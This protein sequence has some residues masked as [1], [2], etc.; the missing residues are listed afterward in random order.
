MGP[1]RKV[2]QVSAQFARPRKPGRRCMPGRKTND[3]PDRAFT[4]LSAHHKFALLISGVVEQGSKPP[5]N[6]QW[7]QH[8]SPPHSSRYQQRIC[9]GCPPLGLCCAKCLQR[10]NPCILNE[11]VPHLLRTFPR[12]NCAWRRRKKWMYSDEMIGGFECLHV[13]GQELR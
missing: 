9:V 2:Q 4:W 12:L 3:G 6:D 10:Y 7:Q 1:V 5:S 13:I 11:R 8:W